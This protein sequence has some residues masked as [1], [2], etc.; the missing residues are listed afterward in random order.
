M[1]IGAY[2]IYQFALSHQR[3]G[4]LITE[5]SGSCAIPEG[6]FSGYQCVLPGYVRVTAITDLFLPVAFAAL[7]AG[8]VLIFLRSP[9][10]ASLAIGCLC[11]LAAAQVVVVIASVNVTTPPQSPLRFWPSLVTALAA[12]LGAGF[13]LL[14]PRPGYPART[15]SA[16]R[17]GSR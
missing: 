1:L 11:L 9:R 2:G 7:V 5:A 17:G 12:L 15:V 13:V 3:V 10:G 4:N 14:L 8:A 6:G 16:S